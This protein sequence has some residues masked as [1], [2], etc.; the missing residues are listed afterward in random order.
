[1]R[2]LALIYADERAW[3]TLSE[4]ER[5]R[6]YERYRAFAAENERKIVRGA[7][8]A[9]TRTSTTVRVRGG[10]TLVTDGPFETLDEPLGGFYV[11]DCDSMDEA[12]E[13]AARIP[14][15]ATGAVEVRPA[16]VEEART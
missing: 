3:E 8:T 6:V 12:V 15:A 4:E 1:V 2:Y 9:P 16:Y 14:G 5:K 11:F 10:G 7:E 13:L